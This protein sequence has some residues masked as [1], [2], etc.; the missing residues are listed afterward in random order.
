[1]RDNGTG[2]RYAEKREMHKQ[3]NKQLISIAMIIFLI[4]I[5]SATYPGETIK[6]KNELATSDVNYSIIK[7]LTAIPPLLIST[8]SAQIFVI[9]PANM[10]PCSFDIIF[11][12][13]HQE[14]P[15][16]TIWWWFPP[17]NYFTKHVWINNNY[18]RFYFFYPGF[19]R[20]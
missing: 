8:T 15:K 9:I 3:A 5:A 6:Y 20:R 2:A 19:F 1:L 16:P 4:G 13:I 7:N 11:T 17:K 14:Q 12:K 10:P 18:N